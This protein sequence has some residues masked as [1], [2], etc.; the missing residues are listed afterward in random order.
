MKQDQADSKRE[1]VQKLLAQ[2]GVCS[3]REAE[4]WISSGEVTVNGQTIKLGDKAELGKDFIKV[5]GKLVLKPEA[6]T[7]VA[8]YKPRETLSVLKHSGEDDD[9]PTIGDYLSR[10]KIRL[11]P[12]GK[13]DF[14]GEGLLLLTNDGELAESLQKKVTLPWIYEIKATGQFG[15][16]T[17]DKVLAGGRVDG[18]RI[19]PI[20]IKPVERLQQKSLIKIALA[21]PDV[22]LFRKYLKNKGVIVDRLKRIAVGNIKLGEMKPGEFRYLKESQ[23]LALVHQPELGFLEYP[24][25]NK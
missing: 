12:V 22:A 17:F 8:F 16:E 25:I 1:R 7:Y 4:E 13:L 14:L 2:A 21:T 24:W 3:R 18:T 20:G 10:V 23:V 6:K 15:Q 5:R 19:K 11:F 9:R